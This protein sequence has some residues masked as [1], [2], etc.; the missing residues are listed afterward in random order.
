M[1]LI[2]EIYS[3]GVLN[4]ISIESK[5]ESLVLVLKSHVFSLLTKEATDCNLAQHLGVYVCY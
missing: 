3:F 2:H 5:D 1:V 4:A